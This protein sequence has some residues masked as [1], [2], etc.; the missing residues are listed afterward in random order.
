MSTS[1]RTRFTRLTLALAVP[2]LLGITACSDSDGDDEAAADDDTTAEAGEAEEPQSG[3]DLALEFA[4]CMRDH[5]VED[6]PDPEIG[7]E[8]SVQ[9]SPGGVDLDDPEVQAA[10]EECQ[11]ILDQGQLSDA[12][13]EDQQAELEEEVL[14]FAQCMREHGIDFPDPD[15]SGGGAVTPELGPGVDPDS[16]EFQD[17]LEACQGELPDDGNS[18]ATP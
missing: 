15:V 17:A 1:T 11:S 7:D 4:Q 12:P 14:A 8:G 13:D 5:G 18:V 10:Q 9:L 2:L 3:A 6:F 16:P